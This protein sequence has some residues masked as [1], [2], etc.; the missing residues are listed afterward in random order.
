MVICDHEKNVIASFSRCQFMSVW[1]EIRVWVRVGAVMDLEMSMLCSSCWQR[2][3]SV[4]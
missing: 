3:P 1:F 2:V 4:E